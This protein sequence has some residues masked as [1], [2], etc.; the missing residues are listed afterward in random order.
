MGGLRLLPDDDRPRAQT[1]GDVLHEFARLDPRTFK[2]WMRV[3]RWKLSMLK[4]EPPPL[5]AK[6]YLK[7]Q[8]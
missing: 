4:I 6:D 8:R 1:D 7:Q 3:A 2:L 5:R